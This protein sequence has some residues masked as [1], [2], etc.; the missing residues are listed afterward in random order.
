[1]ADDLKSPTHES[2]EI[3]NRNAPEWD[4]QMGEGGAF[5]RVLIG[6]NTERLLALQ[7]DE[8]VLDIACGNGA[9]AR[10]MAQLGAR[11]VA[12]NFSEVFI[13]RAMART[14][15][16][17]RITY[18]VVDATDEQQLLALGQGRYDAAVCT[19]GMM[20]IATI[21]P[22]LSALRRLLKP[23]GRFVFSVMH[24]CFNGEGMMKFYEEEDRAGQIVVTRGIKTITYN[25]AGASK[26]LGIATPATPQF[27]F[28]R[29]LSA[30]LGTGFRAGFVV[31]ALEEPVFPPPDAAAGISFEWSAFGEIPPVLITR[32]RAPQPT[33]TNRAP[34][35]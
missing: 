23:G 16:S 21:D 5:Q 17:D 28:M 18:R 13:E 10:R 19:M 27:Y 7:P 29:T 8:L 12:S 15:H 35:S 31:D 9:F 3:W 30:L 6:P 14:P 33:L 32:M 11:V 4:A 34:A 22:L 1:V 24:P 26:G 25:S 2:R 20:D